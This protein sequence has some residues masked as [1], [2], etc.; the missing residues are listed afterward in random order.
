M[1]T[2]TVTTSFHIVSKSVARQMSLGEA[3]HAGDRGGGGAGLREAL[4]PLSGG[5]EPEALM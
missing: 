1:D 2:E 5:L 4:M 3:L